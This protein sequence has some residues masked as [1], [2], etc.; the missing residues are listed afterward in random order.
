MDG[1]LTPGGMDGCINRWVLGGRWAKDELRM[2]MD[3]DM[4]DGVPKGGERIGW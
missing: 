4:E 2:D 1:G 3:M